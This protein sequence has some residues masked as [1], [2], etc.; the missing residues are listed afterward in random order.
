MI[1]ETTSRY[2][3]LGAEIVS[4]RVLDEAGREVNILQPSVAYRIVLTAHFERAAE[5]VHVGVNLRSVSGMVITGQRHPAD[6]RS[7][8]KVAAG[9]R[10]SVTFR[11][12]M[13][14]LPGVY[15]VSGGLWCSGEPHCLHRVVDAGM[16]RILPGNE[17]V[18]FG[19]VDARD[20]EPV[21]EETPA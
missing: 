12:R 8:A 14:M 2:P 19:L 6:G 3:Q 9:A 16:F 10:V 17:V 7:I 20:G 15:F 21:W 4:I 1:P 13:L 11:F 18:S 5:R